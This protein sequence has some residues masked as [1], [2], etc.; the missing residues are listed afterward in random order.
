VARRALV[1]ARAGEQS[2]FFYIREMNVGGALTYIAVT[3]RMTGGT[4]RSPLSLTRVDIYG[5]E[6]DAPD[7]VR[8]VRVNDE[9]VDVGVI[10]AE[11]SYTGIGILTG[12]WEVRTPVDPPIRD[13][14]RFTEASLS[15]QQRLQQRQ[16]RRIKRFRLQVPPTGQLTLIGPRYS[17]LPREIHGRHEILLRVEAVRDREQLSSLAV[18]GESTML[19]SGAAAGFPLP[20]LEYLITE[21][22]GA[23]AVSLSP[24]VI[25]DKAADGVTDQV[26]VVWEGA[27]ASGPIM[28]VEVFDPASGQSYKALA[29]ADSGIFVLPP[30]VVQGVDIA[31]LEIGIMLVGR[32]RQPMSEPMSVSVQ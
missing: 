7:R 30:S 14:D 32:D 16:F 6:P 22:I 27:A 26:A 18:P 17:E 10:K 20:T 2:D 11:I 8:Q 15:E 3:C 21:A 24:R 5:D 4:A 25:V 1:R 9:N 23:A 28:Q 12:W 31:A 29:P 13:I 19:F